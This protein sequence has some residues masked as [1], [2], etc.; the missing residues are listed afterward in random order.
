MQ[1]L[2]QLNLDFLNTYDCGDEPSDA[3]EPEPVDLSSSE[4]G[5]VSPTKDND[6]FVE[7]SAVHGEEID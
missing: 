5:D 6:Y 3:S 7:E 1:P 4:E 2:Q